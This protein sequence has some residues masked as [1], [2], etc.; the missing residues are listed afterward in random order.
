MS[1]LTLPRLRRLVARHDVRPLVFAETGTFHGE[2]AAL[3][4][5]VFERVL[6]CEL[7]PTLHAA[8]RE[9]YP[10][11]PIT[12]VLGDS[13]AV[14]RRWALA[15]DEPVCWYLD[16]HWF[17]LNPNKTRAGAARDRNGQIAGQA[18]GLP[19]WDELAALAARPWPDIIIVDD[20]RD[21]G[22]D[23]PTPEWR[24]VSLE[25]IAAQFPHHREALV[26]HDQAVVY[27]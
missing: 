17:T 15:L 26:L 3:A 5:A 7:S 1:G 12:F 19:L 4:C 14:I 13:R 10:G 11:L 6:T 21:F 27:R 2:R 8:A 20:A 22:T 18:E 23:Q 25:A 9:A 16:A 24:D